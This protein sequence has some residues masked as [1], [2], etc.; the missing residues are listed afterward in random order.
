[1]LK[2]YFSHLYEMY[3]T[4]AF[5][6]IQPRMNCACQFCDENTSSAEEKKPYRLQGRK[7]QKDA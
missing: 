4:A 3:V 2:Y 1:M 5:L 7:S 6:V